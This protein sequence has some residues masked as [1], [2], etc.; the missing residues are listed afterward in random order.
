[1]SFCW[2]ECYFAQILPPT[3]V[4]KWHK[5]VF[6][7]KPQQKLCGKG[8]TRCQQKCCGIYPWLPNTL[9]GDI[10]TPKTYLKH[11][12]S[13]GIWKPRDKSKFT[14]LRVIWNSWYSLGCKLLSVRHRWEAFIML[15]CKDIRLC[16][17]QGHS[18]HGSC[19][20]MCCLHTSV[21]KRSFVP[22]PLVSEAAVVGYNLY[23]NR[24]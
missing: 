8:C 6:F 16:V 14:I 1:M 19:L 18:A 17:R 4:T 10:W 12:T 7:L 3:S 9:W 22:V 24:N 13:G 20:Y 15:P 5:V 11:Q 21:E 2:I 23:I